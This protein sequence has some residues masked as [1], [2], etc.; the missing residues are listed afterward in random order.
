MVKQGTGPRCHRKA[1]PA[2]KSRR[3]RKG[4]GE[5]AKARLRSEQDTPPRRGPDV[6]ALAT[7][8]PGGTLAAGERI[9]NLKRPVGAKKNNTAGIN[10]SNNAKKKK[11]DEES[12]R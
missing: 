8:D 4:R 7:W 2:A 5:R 9:L 1:R 10:T 11:L 12:A 3:R 6:C